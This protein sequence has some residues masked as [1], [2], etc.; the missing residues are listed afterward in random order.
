MKSPKKWWMCFNPYPEGEKPYMRHASFGEAQ[1]EAGRL[2]AITGR[3]IH[4]LELKGT[5][6]PPKSAPFWVERGEV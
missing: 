2:S 5:M 3:K 6:Q 4:V 1:K